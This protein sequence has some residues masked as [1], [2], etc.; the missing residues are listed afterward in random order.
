MLLEEARE[1]L[2][3]STRATKQEIK[4]AFRELA[5]EVHPDKAGSSSE[6]EGADAEEPNAKFI[7]LRAA[8][9]LLLEETAK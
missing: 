3:V 4:A 2:G 6:G 7:A 8:Y 1:L 5:R 9:E